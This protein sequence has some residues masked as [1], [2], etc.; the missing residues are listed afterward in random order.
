MSDA[1]KFTFVNN[2]GDNLADIDRDE[3]ATSLNLVVADLLEHADDSN[4]VENAVTVLSLVDSVPAALV[5]GTA[6]RLVITEVIGGM[7]QVSP[8]MR[9]AVR[10]AARLYRSEPRPGRQS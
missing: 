1:P 7:Q 2:A 9:S 8:S 5:L 3:L 4:Y 6:L 10:M